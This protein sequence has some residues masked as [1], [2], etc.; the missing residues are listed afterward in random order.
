MVAYVSFLKKSPSAPPS[1]AADSVAH[2]DSVARAELKAISRQVDQ[3]RRIL[4]DAITRLGQGFGALD[5]EAKNQRDLLESLLSSLGRGGSKG[6]EASLSFEIF[7]AETANVLQQFTELLAHV[8]KESVKTVYQVDDMSKELAGIFELLGSVDDISTE[9]DILAV[10]ASIEAA[11]AGNKGN[12]FGVIASNVRELSKR[13]RSFNQKIGEQ[14]DRARKRVEEVRTTMSEMASRDLNLALSG[15][16]RVQQ[17][18]LQLAEFEKF[19]HENV[20]KA[21]SSAER[22]ATAT[23][24]S[25]T[26]LQFEDILGQL[27]S[28]IGQ[29]LE[30][31]QAGTSSSLA[32]ADA[33]GKAQ[34]RDVVKQ[35]SMTPGDVE[36][37]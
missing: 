24:V 16:E 22:I 3:A 37:F 31:L 4:G 17:M 6:T 29:R 5:T 33:R 9:T 11:H 30:H 27:L 35:Q 34:V 28:G 36:L 23:S 13:T 10:N 18:L 26:A 32:V 14:V 7:A 19:L 15:K 21:E 8:S 2:T 12:S 1:G 20:R 25:I